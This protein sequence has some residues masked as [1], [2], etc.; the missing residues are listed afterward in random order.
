MRSVSGKIASARSSRWTALDLHKNQKETWSKSRLSLAFWEWN[1]YFSPG[2]SQS[3]GRFSPIYLSFGNSIFIHPPTRHMVQYHR[4]SGTKICIYFHWISSWATQQTMTTTATTTTTSD[5]KFFI[6]WATEQRCSGVCCG[7]FHCER[8]YRASRENVTWTQ[9]VVLTIQRTNR[10]SITCDSCE[11]FFFLLSLRL[12]VSFS[13]RRFWFRVS[14]VRASLSSLY[15]LLLVGHESQVILKW[16]VIGI[17][18][19]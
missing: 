7:P 10:P 11:Q 3:R 8:A 13:I 1:I 5:H 16:Y 12:F 19:G 6:N 4:I 9:N 14:T 18:Y 2:F 17:G 15:K